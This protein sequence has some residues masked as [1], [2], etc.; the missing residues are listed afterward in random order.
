MVL[1]IT[2][3]IGSICFSLYIKYT[4]NY[5]RAIRIIPS[6]S[7]L[8]MILTCIM[9]NTTHSLA[10]T[11]LLVA[12]IGFSFSPLVP[13]SYDLGCELCFPIGEAQVIGILNGGAMIFT[14][15]LTIVTTSTIS[16]ENKQ[17]SLTVLIVYIVLIFVGTLV[18]FFIKIDLKRRK[19]EK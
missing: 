14:F 11:F 4:A 6:S 7:L 17:N 15:V 18:Y 12:C 2:G 10:L 8:F 5:K 3:V 16:F 19:A 13:I 9:L 1:I